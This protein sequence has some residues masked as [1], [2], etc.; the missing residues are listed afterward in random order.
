M[1]VKLSRVVPLR[2]KITI[3]ATAIVAL[4][5]LLASLAVTGLLRRSI[6]DDTEA[7]LVGRLDAVEVQVVSGEVPTIL[8]STGREVGQIQVLDDRGTI[9][10]RTPGLAVTTRFDVV[11]P[12]APGRSVSANVSGDVIDNDPGEDYRLV[13][14]TVAAS[15]GDFTIYAVTSLDPAA[16]AESYLRQRLL[17]VFPMV[18]LV[19]GLVVFRV[20][21][22]ALAPVDAMRSEVDRIE[23]T[24]LSTRVTTEERDEEIT[25]LGRTLNHLLD[26]LETAAMRQRLFA[27]AA[28]HELRSPLSA[29]RTELE[30][31]LQYPDRTD[32]QRTATDSLVEVERLEHLARDLRVLT[33]ATSASSSQMAASVCDLR[34]V[35]VDEVHRRMSRH[36]LVDLT[37][38]T[39]VPVVGERNAVVQ[40]VR[41]LLD[42]AERHATSRV[43]VSVTGGG[44]L[45]VTNDGASIA[46]DECELIFDPFTRLDEARAL[47]AGGS[48]LGLA[49]VRATM[50]T[51][52]GTVVCEPRTSGAAFVA[53]F[54]PA[55]E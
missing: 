24:D 46:P 37:G 34:A 26:R 14:R 43:E 29:I 48:G 13:A 40:V 27:A 16:R 25:N 10:A 12:P 11:D 47:D 17:L 21:A 7:L 9:V 52:G 51:V 41:N 22:R 42:N 53:T 15:A 38:T 18:I 28:S 36:E 39:P 33:T 19:V 50:Q 5:L 49:I 20:V 32:W 23:A 3:G 55:P 54:A 6:A 2:W 1:T 8:E 45:S 35:V 30:V 44:V 31:G 4:S